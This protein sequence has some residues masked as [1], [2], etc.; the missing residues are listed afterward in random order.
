[1]NQ[2][3]TTPVRFGPL[4]EY[5]RGADTPDRRAFRDL[6][7][8]AVAFAGA[9]Q[10]AAFAENARETP[11]SE[12]EVTPLGT[13]RTIGRTPTTN[14]FLG[15]CHAL[16]LPRKQAWLAVGVSYGVLRP[17]EAFRGHREA[18]LL[19]LPDGWET[20]RDRRRTLWRDL[21]VTLIDAQRREDDATEG[22][23][24]RDQEIAELKAQVRKLETDLRKA[25]GRIIP[26]PPPNVNIQP[27]CSPGRRNTPL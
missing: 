11:E 4:I 8:I 12:G 25:G 7:P 24:S 26:G 19:T 13:I 20:L 18:D 15:I 9:P 3:P 1:M 22:I 16:N 5:A 17:D 23:A 27:K 21:G 10:P 6:A 2:G 14:G